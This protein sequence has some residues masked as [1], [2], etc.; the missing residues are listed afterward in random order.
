MRACGLA[1]SLGLLLACAAPCAAQEIMD[2]A[3]DAPTAA[4]ERAAVHVSYEADADYTYV[5]GASTKLP[6]GRTGRVSEQ[7][8]SARFVVAPRWGDGPI[9]RFG[10]ALQRYSFGLPRLAP[11][12]NRLQSISAIVGMD[13][14][15]G[16]SWLVRIEAEPGIYNSSDDIRGGDFNVPFI[17]GGSYIAGA[18]LQWVLGLSV[19]VNRRYP[20]IPA[21]GVRWSF[22]DRWTLNA[23]LPTPRLEYSWTKET[24]L[25]A[26]ADLRGATYRVDGGF[27]D[28]HG[29]PR[30][31]NAVVEYDEIRV[32]A[33][34]SWKAYHAC[35]VEIEGGWLPYRDFNFHRAHQ[36]FETESG[37]AY[38]QMAVSAKF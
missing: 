19:D 34:I 25:F 2:Q 29:L 12:P 16:N 30:L 28:A 22:M 17:I 8:A 32:G 26:G 37:A 5:G 10:L 1:F 23:V 35:T 15:L 33:G 4:P 20:V 38:G 13:L 3:A 21:I 11:L 31:N 27:G 6:E 7:S 18:D 9:Y 36:N 14:Q 24:T